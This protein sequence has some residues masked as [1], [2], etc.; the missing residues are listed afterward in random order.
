[1]DA[2]EAQNHLAQAQHSYDAGTQPSLPGWAPPLCGLLV[3]GAI[4]MAGL[5]PD[6]ALL[7]LAAIAGGALLAALALAVLW[8]IRVRQGLHGIRGRARS[9]VVD[10]ATCAAVYV[11]LGLGAMPETRLVYAGLGVVAGVAAWLALR[12]KVTS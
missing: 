10:L 4:T 12:K 8:R 11:V 1:M 7:R 3:A 6:D 5:A 9:T 2:N